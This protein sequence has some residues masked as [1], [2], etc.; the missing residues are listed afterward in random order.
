MIRKLL[1]CEPLFHVKGLEKSLNEQWAKLGTEG[2]N[3]FN[4][5]CPMMEN[6]LQMGKLCLLGAWEPGS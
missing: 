4:L 2:R 3:C 6:S 5:E 1:N